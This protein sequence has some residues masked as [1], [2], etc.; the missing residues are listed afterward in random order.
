MA[1][2]LHASRLL[3]T[4]SPSP[5]LRRLARPS[6]PLS[7]TSFSSTL[8]PS[9][10]STPTP[11]AYPKSC[12]RNGTT[13][14]S[15]FQ[16][17]SARLAVSFARTATT[18]PS[19]P[20][21]AQPAEETTTT[22]PASTSSSTLTNNTPEGSTYIDS[23]EGSPYANDWDVDWSTSFHGIASAP[24]SPEVAEILRR[25]IKTK[26]VEIKPDGILYL[27]E[28]KYRNIL[29][30]AFGPGGWGMVPRG[31]VV[32]GEKIVTREWALVV[33]GR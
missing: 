14:V 10:L 32:V 31:P 16:H 8:L 6:R 7:T 22:S 33:Q 21:P 5:L 12:L 25:P 20:A 27:P 28:I 13:R 18:I 24:F 1:S 17:P 9:A 19:K 23:P 30:D 11:A 15:K 29:F 26:D 4:G 2:S 3:A